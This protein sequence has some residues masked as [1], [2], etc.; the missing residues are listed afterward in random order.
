MVL[1]KISLARARGGG[2]L[3]PVMKEE[4]ASAPPC[5]ESSVGD[6]L[7]FA[8]D[9]GALR[10]QPTHPRGSRQATDRR[11][12][13]WRARCFTSI[14]RSNIIAILGGSACEESWSPGGA[15]LARCSRP[16]FSADLGHAPTVRMQQPRPLARRPTQGGTI[17]ASLLSGPRGERE[18]GL[19]RQSAALE[20]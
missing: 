7:R 17:S 8:T 16:S 15:L 5:C 13:T 12:I 4:C 18:L 19:C 3:R 20:L 10:A 11:T 9:D 1:L 2:M 6:V 14:L